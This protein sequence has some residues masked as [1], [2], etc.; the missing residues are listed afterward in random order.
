MMGSAQGELA[1]VHQWGQPMSVRHLM[2][3]A[4]NRTLRLAGFQMVRGCSTD[5]AISPF[6]PAR[7]TIRQAERAGKSG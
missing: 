2:Q 3:V 6:L 4:V 5:P 1:L 7:W